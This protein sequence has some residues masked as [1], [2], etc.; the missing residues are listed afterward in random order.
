MPLAALVSD[1]A[2]GTA[3]GTVDDRPVT[4]VILDSRRAAPGVLWA[5]LPGARTHGARHAAEPLAAPAAAIL[6]DAEGAEILAEAGATLPVLVS[7]DP[8]AAMARIAAR[9]YRHP[10]EHIT[11]YGVTG[12]NGKSTTTFLLQAALRA[13]G[14]HAGLI[15][16]I[17]FRL[18]DDPVP[19]A[20]SST[21]TTPESVDLQAIL[22][23]LVSAGADSLAMEVSSH[24][25]ALQRVDGI[26]FDVAGFAN[27]GVDHL[28]F[29]HDV[30]SYFAAKAR[31]F[32]PGLCRRAVLNVD[33]EHGRLLASRVQV[34]V[35]TVSLDAPD[36]N[37]EQRPATVG[38][39]HWE[40]TAHGSRAVF[41]V[42]D[43]DLTAEIAL[44]GEHNVRNALLALG[45]LVAAGVTDLEAAV[46]GFAR[47]L[48]P[49]RMEPVVLPEAPAAARRTP[50][51]HVDFAHTPQAVEA[52]GTAFTGTAGPIIVVVGSGGDRDPGKRAPIGAAAARCADVLVVTD[53][54]PRTEDP[55]AIRAQIIAGAEEAR[56]GGAGVSEIVDGGDRR[57]AIRSAL[58]RASRTG[59]TVL[60][61]GRGHERTQHT[62]DGAVDFHDPTVVVQQWQEL[63][64][65]PPDT[66]EQR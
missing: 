44:P 60:V 62:A 64:A 19:G 4:G 48:V 35:T 42:D 2:L 47:V 26:V 12:T 33:D 29:H 40:P 16:T 5:A 66:G 8:R 55:A 30:D 32:T 14:Q 24:A 21:V 31:L 49:G 18:D 39:R 56:A 22:A 53:D 45:M 46:A 17:G 20:S 51:V 59:G 9:L 23:S 54:N 63:V 27:L 6:T 52:A 34:P 61:L 15:G 36:G 13:T 50:R 41:T 28:D 25:L 11:T 43:R 57:T 1:E 37:A 58:D 38:V 7:D 3:G 10:A 65:G